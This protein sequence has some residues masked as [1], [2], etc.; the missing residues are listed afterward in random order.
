MDPHVI[1]NNFNNLYSI[2]IYRPEHLKA[3]VKKL[4]TVLHYLF[5]GSK[6]DKVLLAKEVDMI[7]NY[8]GLETIR[9]GD[10]LNVSFEPEG[11]M[12][13]LMIAHLILY[14]FVENCFVHGADVNPL[15]SWIKI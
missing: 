6:S 5:K 14:S 2:S 4:K 9:Y 11:S 1:F 8:I 15:K 10:R 13:G 3:T 7:R 12:H